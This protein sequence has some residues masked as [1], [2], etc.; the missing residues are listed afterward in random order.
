MC[1]STGVAGSDLCPW[2]LRNGNFYCIYTASRVSFIRHND[3]RH[4]IP[5]GG[6]E[7]VMCTQGIELVCT[8]AQSRLV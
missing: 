1:I 8:S 7:V 4:L 6:L 5:A 3:L 2:S